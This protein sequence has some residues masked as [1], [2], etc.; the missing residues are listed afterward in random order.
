MVDFKKIR[1]TEPI[2]KKMVLTLQ[3]E[4][5]DSHY[6]PDEAAE[7]IQYLINSSRADEFSNLIVFL[8]R[9]SRSSMWELKNFEIK[10]EEQPPN[11]SSKNQS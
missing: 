5:F 9:T 7:K 11:A 1:L 2:T 6:T 4:L 8:L 10:E 3:I